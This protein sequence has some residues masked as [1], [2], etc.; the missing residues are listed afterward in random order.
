MNAT[1]IDAATLRAY[2]RAEEEAARAQATLKR[3]EQRLIEAAAV[4]LG[5]DPGAIQATG[6]ERE[7]GHFIVDV[8]MRADSDCR[9]AY[10]LIDSDGEVIGGGRQQ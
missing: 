6:I 1:K 5:D 10:C 7:G 9:T 3:A 4:V 2:L 8:M